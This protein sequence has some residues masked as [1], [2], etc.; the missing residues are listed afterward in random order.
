VFK[1]TTSSIQ[2][3]RRLR[4]N[5]TLKFDEVLYIINTS[6]FLGE[7]WY[8]PYKGNKCFTDFLENT[9]SAR[10]GSMFVLPNSA[11]LEPQNFGEPKPIYPLRKQANLKDA[12]KHS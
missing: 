9:S 6:S 1:R 8:Y 5:E 11:P 10:E 12:M 4:K 3:N 2:T 7:R